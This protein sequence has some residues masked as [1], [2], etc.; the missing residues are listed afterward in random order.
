VNA[1]RDDDAYSTNMMKGRWAMANLDVDERGVARAGGGGLLEY[2]RP[3]SWSAIVGGM[4]TALGIQLILTLLGV[5]LGMAAVNPMTDATPATDIAVGTIV[6][7]FLSGIISFGTGGWVAGHM[8]GVLRTGSGSLHGVAA[9]A[10]AAVFGATVTALAGSPV[11]GGAAA[12]VGAANN[13][14]TGSYTFSM[15]AGVRG[16]TAADGSVRYY[17]AYGRSINETEARAAADA[18]RRAAGKLAMST[19]AAF[20]VSMAAAGLGG[21][22]GRSSPEAMLRGQSQRNTPSG[23]VRPA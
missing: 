4:V 12:G 23:T 11:L 17:D 5:G 18:A 9:W 20:L 7:L 2:W 14:P 6:W 10:L 15:P 21:M 16:T 13:Q 19:G 3:F 22:L 8:S 1:R